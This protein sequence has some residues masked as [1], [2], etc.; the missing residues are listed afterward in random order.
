MYLVSKKYNAYCISETNFSFTV[1]TVPFKKIEKAVQGVF[2][3]PDL[4]NLFRKF[5]SVSTGL[6]IVGP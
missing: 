5:H 6:A 2:M 3:M 1:L 4:T